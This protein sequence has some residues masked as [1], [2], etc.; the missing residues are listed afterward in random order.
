MDTEDF[1][2]K[3]HQLPIG[4]E[5]ARKRQDKAIMRIFG[6]WIEKR[7]KEYENW[8]TAGGDEASYLGAK[9]KKANVE[10]S[11][12]REMAMK[13]LEK[14]YDQESIPEQMAEFDA[15]YNNAEE[16]EWWRQKYFG[17]VW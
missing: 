5:N 15:A 9:A 10:Y 12:A 6:S 3:F 7:T 11:V 2:N 1:M 4:G 8:V 13:F 14:W 16:E 17:N